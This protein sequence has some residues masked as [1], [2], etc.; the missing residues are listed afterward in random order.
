MRVLSWLRS[1]IDYKCSVYPPC[2]LSPLSIEHRPA[3]HFTRKRSCYLMAYFFDPNSYASTLYGRRPPFARRR[4]SPPPATYYP[5]DAAD[6]YVRALAEEQA[7]RGA[8][9]DAIKREREARQ[10]RAEEEAKAAMR[11]RMRER[12]RA[13]Q[14]PQSMYSYAPCY[15]YPNFGS[16][17]PGFAYPE[18]G[19][20]PSSYGGSSDMDMDY[21][22]EYPRYFP[23]FTA[24]RPARE[25]VRRQ[26]Q[27]APGLRTARLQSRTPTFKRQPVSGSSINHT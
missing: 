27:P 25:S 24:S 5:R 20:S 13:R 2:P 9:Q 14:R 10:K 18:Y 8:L 15:G 3:S 4:P 6:P 21:E 16:G 12:E 1:L 26:A 11:E 19:Y 22:D 17:F 23:S 7:A